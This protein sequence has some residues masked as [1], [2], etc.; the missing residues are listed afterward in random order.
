MDNAWVR[1]PNVWL[2]SQKYRPF[3]ISAAAYALST[4]LFEE[5]TFIQ[6]AIPEQPGDRESMRPLT[7]IDQA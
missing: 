1:L 7:A 5:R 3:L 4:W 2:V 6:R